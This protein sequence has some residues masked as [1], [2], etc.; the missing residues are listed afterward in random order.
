MSVQYISNIHYKKIQL[1]AEQ[2]LSQTWPE[3]VDVEKKWNMLT[4]GEDVMM[5]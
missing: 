1:V 5:L 4:C 3:T 2:V